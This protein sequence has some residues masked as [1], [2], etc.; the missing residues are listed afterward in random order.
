MLTV[1]A[2]TTN[3]GDIS[4]FQNQL[5]A[6]RECSKVEIREQRTRN[7]VASFTLAVTFKPDAVKPAVPPT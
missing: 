5:N 1:E 3:P 2:Q 6:T 4:V 7:N